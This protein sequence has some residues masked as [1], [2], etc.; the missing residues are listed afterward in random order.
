MELR[1]KYRMTRQRQVVLEV[2]RK[3]TSHPTADEVYIMAREKLPNISLGTVYRNLETLTEQ[4]LIKRIELADDRMRFDGNTEI[5]YHICCIRCGRVEDVPAEPFGA[6]E[7]IAKSISD[8]RITGHHIEF[9]GIC[10]EC[11]QK[12][13][14][15]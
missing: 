8:Y 1:K 7:D 5:H 15:A 6:I 2:L 3:T 13:K 11:Q 10:P 12:E 4:G 9:A 14:N